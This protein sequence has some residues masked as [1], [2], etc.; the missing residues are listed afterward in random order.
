MSSCCCLEESKIPDDFL[1]IG[2]PRSASDGGTNTEC[3]SGND[4]CVDSFLRPLDPLDIKGSYG[5]KLLSLSGDMSLGGEGDPL[6]QVCPVDL[7][8]TS[9]GESSLEGGLT[10]DADC[11][12][13]SSGTL[14]FLDRM[15]AK[16]DLDGEPGR[17]IICGEL[18]PNS[19]NGVLVR[20]SGVLG[21]SKFNAI[22]E[23]GAPLEVTDSDLW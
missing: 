19:S 6:F 15:L 12:R 10:T 14:A 13:L 18:A 7:N 4:R 3:K 8:L 20:L 23:T 17:P 1:E 22:L 9:N 21:S 2:K 11:D 16:G 5:G